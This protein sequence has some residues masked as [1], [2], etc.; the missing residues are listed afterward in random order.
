MV[1]LA[2]E[3]GLPVELAAMGVESL[4]PEPLQGPGVSVQQYMEQ[5]PQVGL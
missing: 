5:L 3:C 1:I 2:R 4:V